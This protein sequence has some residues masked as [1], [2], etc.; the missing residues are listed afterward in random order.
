MKGI[1]PIDLVKR[2][3]NSCYIAF[4]M[5]SENQFFIFALLQNHS[6]YDLLFIS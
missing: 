1:Y 2:Y 6:F 4:T 5:I 3:F